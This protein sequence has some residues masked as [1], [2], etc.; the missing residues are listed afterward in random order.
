M[1]MDANAVQC[2]ACGKAASGKFCNHCGAALTGEF[3][4]AKWSRQTAIPW[5]ALGVA[6]VS[7]AVSLLSWFD[8][9]GETAAPVA[10]L[11]RMSE[12]AAVGPA[13][14]GQPPDLSS[15]SPREAA[16]RLFNR[17]MTASEQG[18]SEEVSRFAPMAIA[19]YQRV[20]TLDNDARYHLAL[21]HMTAGDLQGARVQI[22]LLRKAAPQHLLALMLEHELAARGGNKEKTAGVNKAFLTAYAA[23]IAKGRPEYLD[24]HSSIERFRAAA[25]G[26]K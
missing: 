1:T 3:S 5:V 9:G 11:M 21:L 14:P 6:S 2:P 12:A 19:A 7:L 18:Y 24:H 23:E 15:M 10:P 13:T 16:D 4:R 17:V 8:R 20:G 26:G 22:D 25:R